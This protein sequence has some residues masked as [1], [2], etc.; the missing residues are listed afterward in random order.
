MPASLPTLTVADAAAWRR[1][2]GVNNAKS[3]GVLLTV[4][5]KD[6]V[7]L[8]TSLTYP[9]ALDEALCY[10]WIDSG[11][12]KRADLPGAHYFRFTKRK[13]NG[14]WSKR[15]V[16]FVERLLKDGRMQA[17][18]IACVE[19]AKAD[20]RW[21]S[22]YA[23]SA[24]AELPSDFL[25]A[26]EAVPAA[27]TTYETLNR[28]NRWAIYFRLLQLKTQAGREKRIQAYVIMLAEGKTPIPQKK[29]TSPKVEPVSDQ[30]DDMNS[31]AQQDAAP[32]QPQRRRTR[33]GRMAPSY[34]EL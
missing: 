29:V 20:G 8:P 7:S 12:R 16:G 19:A 5:M 34:K 13:P 25:T 22:A 33:S 3:K 21:N 14:L 10:G 9:Q 32:G 11:G 30:T 18:G 28:G 15:N 4:A 2:L 24:T 26:V 23:G 1:W 27:K 17:P 6:V 31:R